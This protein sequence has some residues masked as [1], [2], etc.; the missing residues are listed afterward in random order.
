MGLHTKK[1]FFVR[2]LSR[3]LTRAGLDS[4]LG[5]QMT[6][7]TEHEVLYYVP[8]PWPDAKLFLTY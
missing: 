4:G 7:N 1:T 2:R 5:S 8:C 3:T 6:A